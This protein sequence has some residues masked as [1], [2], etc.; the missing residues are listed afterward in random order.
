MAMVMVFGVALH[1]S[2]PG[3]AL[4][5]VLLVS[6]ISLV[7]VAVLMVRQVRRGSWTNADASNRAERPILFAV[8]IVGLAVLVGGVL[9]FRPGSFQIRGAIGVLALLAA[10]AVITKWVKVSLHMAF[11]AVA[12]TTLLSLGSPIGWV[13]LAVLP[14]L[15]WSRLTLKRHQPSEVAIGLILG[16]VFGYAIVNL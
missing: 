9:L 13:L 3:D 7:P 4:R 8:A 12:T 15:A 2:T 6:V 1:L 11:G 10:C 5:T 16:V 14:A